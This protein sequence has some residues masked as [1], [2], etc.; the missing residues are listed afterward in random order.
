[1]TD[2]PRTGAAGGFGLAASTPGALSVVPRLFAL[3]NPIGGG[4]E[5]PIRRCGWRGRHPDPQG[6]F[7]SI[8]GIG[9]GEIMEAEFLGSV[10]DRGEK[11]EQQIAKMVGSD[12]IEIVFAFAPGL[13]QS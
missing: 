8:A 5:I 10:A 9:E 13:D 3:A 6:S 1:M 11:I 7:V 4:D 2:G 12:T